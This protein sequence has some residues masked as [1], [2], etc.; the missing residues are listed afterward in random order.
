MILKTQ[1]QMTLEEFLNLPPGEGDTT[2]ELVDGK[3][4]PK[5]S[6]TFHHSKLTRALL[7]PVRSF[8]FEF[9]DIA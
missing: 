8:F 4:F 2:Y 6:P 9:R 3:I 1:N 7:L 5:M